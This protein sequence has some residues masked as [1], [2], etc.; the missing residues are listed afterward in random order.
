MTGGCSDLT[1]MSRGWFEAG[2]PTGPPGTQDPLILMSVLPASAP[3]PEAAAQPR[4]RGADG[5]KSE[6]RGRNVCDHSQRHAVG[7]RLGAS[8]ENGRQPETL[9]LWEQVRTITSSLPC[10]RLAD[11]ILFI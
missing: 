6:A 9:P 5:G 11:I 4:S 2:T 3:Q 8:A 7:C 10:Y 1:E